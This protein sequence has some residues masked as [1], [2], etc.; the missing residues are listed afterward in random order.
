MNFGRFAPSAQFTGIA[1][2]VLL[3]GGLVYAAQRISYPP[4]AAA[5]IES[6]QAAAGASDSTSWEAALYASQAANAST[7][8]TAPD[9][10]LVNQ[11][12]QAAQST[13]VTDTVAR[14]IFIQLSNAKSQGL[15]NDVP[16]QDQIV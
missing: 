1:V 13:N 10:N 5:T 12:L 7:S 14:T 3:A 15:G 4:I 6:E 8:L 16:T 9:P 2:S 11:F